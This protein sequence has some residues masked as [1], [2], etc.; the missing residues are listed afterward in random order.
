MPEE[1]IKDDMQDGFYSIKCSMLVKEAEKWVGV[2]E[3]G[4]NKGPEVEMFQKEVDGKAQGEPWC[5]SFVQFCINQVDRDFKKTYPDA[6]RY[7]NWL[8]KTEHCL[9]CW[10]RTATEARINHDLHPGSVIIWQ[11]FKN[12]KATSAGHVGIIRK[13]LANGDVETIEGNTKHRSGSVVRE[14]DGVFIMK[15]RLSYSGSFRIKGFLKPWDGT[16]KGS[17]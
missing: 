17:S 3:R 12:N 7:P 5:M 11:H 14:G 16:Y 2:K 4:H 15:R 1:I 13:V 6:N 10:N 8:Y 9:N